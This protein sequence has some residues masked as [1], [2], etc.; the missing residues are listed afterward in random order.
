[1]KKTSAI[2]NLMLVVMIVLSGFPA[3]TR[4]PDLNHDDRIDLGETI[5]Q[6]RNFARSADHPD[7]FAQSMEDA[8]TALQVV[9]GLKQV[10]KSKGSTQATPFQNII[11]SIWCRI[12][13]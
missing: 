13:M 4:S 5:I 11:M 6:V 7:Q 1:M 3:G 2:V 10:I 9:A 12:T 8:L